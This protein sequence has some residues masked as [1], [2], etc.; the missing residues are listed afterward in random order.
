M[1]TYSCITRLEGTFYG[2]TPNDTLNSSVDHNILNTSVAIQ[3]P[4]YLSTDPTE[5]KIMISM[6]LTLYVG[7]FQVD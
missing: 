4:N 7:I 1:M 5:A 2:E 3:N 6:A